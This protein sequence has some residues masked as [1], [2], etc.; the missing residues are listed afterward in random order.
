MRK[1]EAVANGY[2]LLV[3]TRAVCCSSHVCVCVQATNVGEDSSTLPPPAARLRPQLAAVTTLQLVLVYEL[4][5]SESTG[6]L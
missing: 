1:H 4:A 3:G 2:M 6:S 5:G